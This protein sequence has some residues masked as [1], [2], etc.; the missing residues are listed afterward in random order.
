MKSDLKIEV[1]EL[2]LRSLLAEG[3]Q[4]V[5]QHF[6]AAMEQTD[7]DTAFLLTQYFEGTPISV[8]SEQKKITQAQMSD[9][10]DRAKRELIQRMKKGCQVKN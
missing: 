5:W 8:L 4:K 10:I 6:E 2:A 9:W 3:S 1:R 7:E